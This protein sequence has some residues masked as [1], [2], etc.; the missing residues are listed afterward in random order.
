MV[1]KKDRLVIF[2]REFVAE[3]I[4]NFLKF[5]QQSILQS[6]EKL[7]KTKGWIYLKNNS[8]IRDAGNLSSE[9]WSKL[10][11]WAFLNYLC[12][13]SVPQPSS[14]PDLVPSHYLSLDLKRSIAKNTCN[15]SLSSTLRLFLILFNLVP[16]ENMWNKKIKFLQNKMVF[17]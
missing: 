15:D 12:F 14:S 6:N 7:E 16:S 10:S 4:T 1:N 9:A 11:S 17:L 2:S 13:E 3:P 8:E 5:P